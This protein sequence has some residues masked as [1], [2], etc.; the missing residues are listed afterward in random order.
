MVEL[1]E[2]NVEME[3]VEGQANSGVPEVTKTSQAHNKKRKRLH[4]ASK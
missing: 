4:V 1:E 2:Q 3:V